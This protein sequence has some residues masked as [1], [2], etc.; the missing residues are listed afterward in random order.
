MRVAPGTAAAGRPLRA[1]RSF[2]RRE[3]RLTAA[4]ERALRGLGDSYLVTPD[5]DPIDLCGV[6]GRR[7]PC[8]L[9]IGTGNGDL[10]LALAQ[11]H[12]END[13]L[14]I[15]VH[16]PGIGSLLLR[17]SRQRLVNLKV[18]CRD[19]ADALAMQIPEASIECIYLFFPDPWPKR[20][21]HKRRLL[22][23]ALTATLRRKLRPHGRLFIATDWEDYAHHILEVMQATP[24]FVNLVGPAMRAPRPRWRPVTRYEQHALRAGRTIHDFTYGCG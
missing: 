18:L 6:F 8:H 7:A 9:E 14:G 19:A 13:H 22:Q 15:E 1:V 20:R 23:P 16:R 3:G 24:G 5:D 17:A 21:H 11:E 4:Q 12:P 10:L 2:V